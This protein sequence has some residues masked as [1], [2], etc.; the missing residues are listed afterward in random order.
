MDNRKLFTLVFFLLI[1]FTLM[2]SAT[3]S[4]QSFERPKYQKVQRKN[5]KRHGVKLFTHKLKQKAT[6]R[7]KRKSVGL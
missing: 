4:G 5:A 6:Y 1:I 7:R 3:C 2:G